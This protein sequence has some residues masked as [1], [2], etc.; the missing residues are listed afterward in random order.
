MGVGLRLEGGPWALANAQALRWGSAFI[1]S[2]ATWLQVPLVNLAKLAVSLATYGVLIR[3]T[4]GRLDQRRAPM[5]GARS[6]RFRQRSRTSP[7]DGCQW[8]ACA[9]RTPTRIVVLF[10]TRLSRGSEPG[11]AIQRCG[12]IG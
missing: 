5:I 8:R 9:S 6:A 4:C 12:Q 2:V 10:R 7:Y 3:S 11:S 1:I